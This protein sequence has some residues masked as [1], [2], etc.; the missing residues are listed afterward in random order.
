MG[1]LPYR[2]SPDLR[3]TVSDSA[4][5]GCILQADY[6]I[7]TCLQNLP[8]NAPRI[9]E[10]AGHRRLANG[11]CHLHLHHRRSLRQ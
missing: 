3:S 1:A 7:L 10:K 5:A 4:A 8:T 11:S 6:I 9:M 2:H